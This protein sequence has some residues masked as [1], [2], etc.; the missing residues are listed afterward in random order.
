MNAHGK[1]AF[2]ATGSPV[3]RRNG[4]CGIC[5]TAA[6]PVRGCVCVMNCILRETS[7]PEANCKDLGTV[8]MIHLR[9]KEFSAQGARQRHADG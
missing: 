9:L 5:C 7:C 4:A 2:R 1:P 3:P 6:S 8:C